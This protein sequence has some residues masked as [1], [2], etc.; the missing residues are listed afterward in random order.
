MK[1][2]VL[3]KARRG[4]ITHLVEG[5]DRLS[6]ALQTKL[7]ELVLCHSDIHAGNL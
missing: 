3:M 4:E 6:I 5:A 2:A 1:L 7:Q